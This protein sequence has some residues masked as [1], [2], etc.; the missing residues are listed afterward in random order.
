[1]FTQEA[2]QTRRHR[3]PTHK[4]KERAGQL[5]APAASVQNLWEAVVQRRALR[6]LPSLSTAS[7]EPLGIDGGVREERFQQLTAVAAWASQDPAP[8]VAQAGPGR[9]GLTGSKLEVAAD[10]FYRF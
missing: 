1:M 8:H 2:Q 7:C 5:I 3:N 4:A 9:T 10:I 6:V